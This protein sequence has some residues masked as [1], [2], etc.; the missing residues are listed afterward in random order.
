MVRPTSYDT[1]AGDY[2]RHRVAQHYAI[3]TLAQTLA[4]APR[5]PLLEV[6]CGTGEYVEALA[7][8][9]PSPSLGMDPSRGMLEQ[10]RARHR[11]T[12]VQS[13]A[14]CLPFADQSLGMIFSINVIHHVADVG[15]YMREAHRAL[16][17]GGLVCT[18]TDSEAIIRRRDPLSRYWPATVAPELER[19][20]S[21]DALSEAMA[22]AGFRD[23]QAREAGA[24]FAIEN[25][26]PYRDKAY[27]CL[28]LIAEEDFLAGL[29][30]LER[31]LQGG[32]LEGF[33][34]LTFLH[35]VRA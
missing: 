23:L 24:K 9:H 33:S 25:D 2:A 16:V 26:A 31:A 5:A 10:A 6:G 34:E 8:R 15:A 20:H 17:P 3:E 7:A 19:Y 28:E 18:A 22:M 30:A 11:V 35:G 13:Q 21:I 29:N 14:A 4:R 32:P 12:F 27:S 1:T